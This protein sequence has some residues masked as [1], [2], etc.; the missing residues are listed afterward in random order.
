MR[1]QACGLDQA[2]LDEVAHRQLVVLDDVNNSPS[3]N[4]H[5]RLYLS[6]QKITS[7]IDV[8][9]MTSCGY[10]GLLRLAQVYPGRHW[11]TASNNLPLGFADKI[12]LVAY[13]YYYLNHR[14]FRRERIA[15]KS[16]AQSTDA[17]ILPFAILFFQQ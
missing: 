3:L 14:G 10:F 8:P 4:P 1:F 15:F 17:A 6:E 16:L 2:Y 5:S 12:A 13:K 9:I 11:V 7:L